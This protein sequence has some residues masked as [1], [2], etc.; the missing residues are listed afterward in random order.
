MAKKSGISLKIEGFEEI[1]NA[2]KD[3]G[4]SVD[5]AVDSAVRQS[6]QIVQIELKNEMQQ[7]NVDSDLINA[8]PAP[9]IFRDGNAVVAKVGYNKGTYNPAKLSNGYK[10]VFLNYG[11]PNRKKYGKVI[12]KGFIQRAKKSATPKVRKA[13]KEV[14]NKIIARLK[15]EK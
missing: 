14:F 10:V 8:M 7:S 1:L 12:A 9:E 15:N 3:A 11:T 13:Q 2:I 6:A 4:G 5:K